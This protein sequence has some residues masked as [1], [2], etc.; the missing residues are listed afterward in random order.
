MDMR[1]D[2]QR[3]RAERTQRAWSQEHL[4]NATDLGLRT[5]QRIEATGMASN[6]SAQ[7]IAAA[8]GIAVAELL[9][10]E[11]IRRGSGPHTWLSAQRFWVLL[12]IA[13]IAVIAS[14]PQLTIPLAALWLWVGFEFTLSFGR[15]RSP[16]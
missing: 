14:P 6:E 15:R 11:T 8:F 7:A 3:I 4:A 5:V 13:T 1:V 2:S 10:P 12:A 9:E 16:S